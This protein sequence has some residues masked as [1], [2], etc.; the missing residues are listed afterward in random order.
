MKLINDKTD[1]A[2]VGILESR[3]DFKEIKIMVDNMNQ[4]LRDSGFDQYQ[5]R[6]EKEGKKA[7]IRKI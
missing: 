3:H 1:P 5:Y 2:L 7:Y 6:V 4:D